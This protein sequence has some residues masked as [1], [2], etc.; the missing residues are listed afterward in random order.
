VDKA[1]DMKVVEESL[2]VKEDEGTNVAG[3]YT[4]LGRVDQGKG[5]IDG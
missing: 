5:C 3:L 4:R 1:V 2:Y